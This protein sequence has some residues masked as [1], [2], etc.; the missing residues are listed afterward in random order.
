MRKSIILIVTII[1]LVI[2]AFVATG[3]YAVSTFLSF[4][5]AEKAMADSLIK[6]NEQIVNQTA[7]SIA[8]SAEKLEKSL[9]LISKAQV[10]QKF[11]NE[12]KDEAL[13]N[14]LL[15]FKSFKDSNPE[16]E[17]IY[18]GTADKK[19][20]IVP[21]FELP[22]DYDPTSRSWYINAVNNMEITWSEPYL[23]AI[24]GNAI[25][26][27]S[28]PVYNE[29]KI[30]GV[31]SV[32][33]NLSL[34][35]EKIKDIKLGDTGYLILIDQNGIV[36]MHPNKE[37]LGQEIH[38]EVLKELIAKEDEGTVRYVYNDME[39]YAIYSKID[40]LKLNLIGLIKK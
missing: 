3:Y 6:Q 37:Q 21:E 19:M 29:D 1:F 9:Y 16:V 32:D 39:E 31:L 7:L 15:E 34:M 25:I 27:L 24:N 28:L 2:A 12:N 30:I 23:D 20:Y 38:I 40:K 11:V 17:G 14:M 8:D 26:S 22:E 35:V 5:Q 36:L 18:L 13:E 10:F 4:K 33:L